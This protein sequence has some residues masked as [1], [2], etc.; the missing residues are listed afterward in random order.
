M[1][2]PLRQV[3]HPA[4]GAAAPPAVSR[5]AKAQA[6]RSRPVRRGIVY[7]MVFAFSTPPVEAFKQ[8]PPPGDCRLGSFT[9]ALPSLRSGSTQQW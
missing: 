1:K 2:L 4:V 6:Y 7:G 8:K 3:L 5:V 9:R